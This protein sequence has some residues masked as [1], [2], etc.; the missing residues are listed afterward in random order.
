MSNGIGLNIKLGLFKDPYLGLPTFQYT[1]AM[2]VDRI[3][4]LFFS[5]IPGFP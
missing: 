4:E 5:G 1:L 2:S 3:S